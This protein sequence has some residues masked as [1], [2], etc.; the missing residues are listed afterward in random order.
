[1]SFPGRAQAPGLFLEYSGY[2]VIPVVP[3]SPPA[4]DSISRDY[5]LKK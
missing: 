4:A 1:L 3:L 2:R 5:I